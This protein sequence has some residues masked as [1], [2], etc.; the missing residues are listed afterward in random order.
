MERSPFDGCVFHVNTS[1]PGK[2]ARE[3]HLAW[4][5]AQNVQT[6]GVR[7][8]LVDVAAF[9]SCSGRSTCE[10]GFTTTSCGSMS[11]RA[12]STGSTIT[13]RWWPMPGSRPGWHAGACHGILL[14][15]EQYEGQLF[16]YRKQ[17]DASRKTWNHMRPRR[18]GAAGKSWPRSRKVSRPDAVA[19]LRPEPCLEPEPGWEDAAGRCAPYGLLVP[20]VDG[21]IEC[22]KGKTRIVDGFEQS[23]GYREI[24]QFEQAHETITL[25][26]AGLMS[27][28]PAYRASSP[29]GFGLWLDHDWRRNGW[30]PDQPESN[31]FSPQRFESALRRHSTGPMSTSGSTPRSRAGGRRTARRSTCRTRTCNRSAGPARGSGSI[32]A[33][34]VR[35]AHT[36]G[37]TASTP[38]RSASEDSLP[39]FRRTGSPR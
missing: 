35:V 37:A 26:A 9:G 30:K 28:P 1:V 32:R 5:G 29:L 3:P 18:G 33:V 39:C 27:D 15:T 11:H 2:G 13:D 12:T 20:F 19:H 21:L 36:L 34:N 31:Y 7:R 23:Y 38:T 14:D 10:S 4:L 6:R 8:V 17:R 22:A 25:K 16:N 24:T